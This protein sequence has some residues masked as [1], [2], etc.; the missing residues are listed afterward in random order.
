MEYHNQGSQTETPYFSVIL[1]IYNVELYVEACIRSVL[2]QD[3]QD[4]ELILVDD[5]ST[6][7]CPALCD[8]YAKEYAHIQ[9][10]HKINGGLSSARNAG[11]EIARGKYI[12]WV[13]SD[14]WI[15]P[16]ALSALHAASCNAEPDIVKFNFSRVG[17]KSKEITCKIQPGVYEAAADLEAL[18][19]KAFRY[20]GEFSLS[21]WG[22]IYKNAFLREKKLRFVSERVIGSEDYLFNLSAFAVAEKINVIP[23]NLYCYR[24]RPGSLTQRYRW[25]LMDKYTELYRR[26]KA[27]YSDM[28]LLSAYEGKICSFY[29][30]H[31]IHGTC[32]GSEYRSTADHTTEAGRRNIAGFLG[33]AD[34]QYAAKHCEMRLFTRKQQLQIR[35]M[36]LKLEPLFYWMYVIKPKIG[37]GQK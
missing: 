28:G 6:D 12:W 37:K 34:F 13:D 15:Q 32:F 10:I 7:G 11:T 30:W 18:R 4:Y 22:H 3:F 36:R 23:N 8:A 1:P 26:L 19:E 29:V 20:S 9:V 24:L 2:A 16:G 5:G 14:D 17:E 21:A 27:Y 31:L 25:N 35:A 33:T